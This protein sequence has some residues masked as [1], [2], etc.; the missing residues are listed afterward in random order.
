M[1][2]SIR[3]YEWWPIEQLFNIRVATDCITQMQ[4]LVFSDY[5]CQSHPQDNIQPPLQVKRVKKINGQK[6]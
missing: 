3:R 2:N 6:G 5:T 4:E 1:L